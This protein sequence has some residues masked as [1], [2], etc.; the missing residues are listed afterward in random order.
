MESLVYMPAHELFLVL[1]QFKLSHTA[2]IR[3]VAALDR[4]P[5][6]LLGAD[7]FYRFKTDVAL[8]AARYDERELTKAQLHWLLDQ[9]GDWGVPVLDPSRLNE[10]DR[11][12]F[13][14]GYLSTYDLQLEDFQRVQKALE[15]LSANLGLSTT[16][17][18]K[19]TRKLSHP[20]L[21]ARPA[22]Q[23]PP[24][25]PPRGKRIGSEPAPNN[26][27]AAA[28]SER[29]PSQTATPVDRASSN[30]QTPEFDTAGP[31]L[32]E[33][34]RSAGK[35]KNRNRRPRPTRPETPAAKST[36][37][38]VH[39]RPSARGTGAHAALGPHV[40]VR[41]LR[42]DR[43]QV[44]RLGALNSR[45]AFVIASAGPRVGDVVRLALGFD[46]A[47]ATVSGSVNQVTTT[48]LAGFS[49]RFP[50]EQ[51]SGRTDLIELLRRARSAGVKLTRPPARSA[52]RL[53]VSW[54]IRVGTADGGFQTNALDVSS[55]GMFVATNEP[56][57]DEVVF[58]LRLDT[59]TSIQGRAR[60]ARKVDE[61]MALNR[62]LRSGVGLQIVDL[63]TTDR[64]H[65]EAF[66][67]R[68]RAR[69]GKRLLV[70]AAPARVRRIT[71]DLAAAGYNAVAAPDHATMARLADSQ[72]VPPDAALIDES[73]ASAGVGRAWVEGLFAAGN[74]PV[75]P[76]PS[77]ADKTRAVI[78]QLLQIDT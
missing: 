72:T 43:W 31:T 38:T 26:A 22:S 76:L 7:A 51:L 18:P 56:L 48:D 13:Y 73:L 78:D 3:A 55:G 63:S 11:R 14:E 17:T 49:V 35:R 15:G 30:P 32:V 33:P 12:N 8:I 42:G 21:I 68:V 60:V 5:L 59:G 75:V 23:P 45:G 25:P 67:R 37:D 24:L 71:A 28:K 44:A 65:Y 6:K 52:A 19:S 40:D 41:F 39:S 47:V 2:L 61:D 16:P 34:K 36:P 9:V 62:G 46:D 64:E 1:E 53:P 57:A 10:T 77:Q 27:A 54:P 50:A 58:R 74:V 70:G 29:P 20:R 4:S 69:A 66:I